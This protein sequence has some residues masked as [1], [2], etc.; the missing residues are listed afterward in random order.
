MRRLT[1]FLLFSILTAGTALASEF[2]LNSRRISV[3]DGLSGNTINELVQD[4]DGYVWMATNNGLSR[5]DGYSTVNYTSLSSDDRRRLEARIGRI[6]YDGGQGLLWMRTATFMN[7]CYDLAE[8]RFVDWTAR[9]DELRQLN[10]FFLSRHR[11]MFFFGYGFGLRRTQRKDGRFLLTDYKAADG[12]LPSDEVLMLLEDEAQNIWAAT[13]RGVARLGTDELMHHHLKGQAI[14]DAATAA[15]R[16][17]FLST[18]GVATVLDGEGREVL[19]S[20]LPA[21]VGKVGKVNI[22]FV[23]Q[24]RWMLFTPTGTLAMD[25]KSGAW[26]RE[27]GAAA[28]AGGLNQGQLP[29]YHFVANQQGRLLVF[30]DEGPCTAMDLIPNARFASMVGRKFHVATDAEGRLFIATYGNGLFVW[31]PATGQRRHFT[32]E[33]P[34]PIIRSNYLTCIM[35]DRQGGIWV[36]SEATGA[37]CLSVMTGTTANYV[38][39]EPT[40]QGDWANAV[41]AVGQRRDGTIIIGTREGGIYEYDRGEGT[42]RKTDTRQANVTSLFVDGDHRL[43]I[44]TNGEGLLAGWQLY[45]KDDATYHLPENKITDILQDREG[46]IWIATRDGGLLMTQPRHAAQQGQPLSFSQYLN[47]EMNES[48]LHDIELDPQGVLWIA[49]NN[50]IYRLDTRQPHISEAS[51]KRY[52]ATN[53][54]FPANEIFTLHYSPAD[55]SLWVGAAGLGAVKCRF[56]EQGDQLLMT[57]VTTRHGLANNNV[58]SLAEDA[59]G[60]I[61]AGTEEGISRINTRNNIVNNYQPSPVLQGNV[62]TENCVLTTPDGTLLFGTNYGLITM[63]PEPDQPT[64]T[65]LRARITDLRQDGRSVSVFFSNFNYSNVQASLYQ[66]YLEG[67]EEDWRPM[68][69]DH[70]ADYQQLAPGHYVFHL[71]SLGSDNEWQQETTLGIDVPHPW[72]ATWWAWLAYLSVAALFGWYVYRN[73]RERFRLHQQMKVGQQVNEFRLQFF[74]SIT[75]EFR[76]PLAIIKGALDKLATDTG[77]QHALQTAQR[78]TKRLLKLVNQLMEFRKVSTGNLSLHP[79]QGDIIGFV[80]ATCQDFWP[81]AQQKSIQTTFI[82]FARS[83]PMTFDRQVV[84]T[85]VYNLVSNAIKYTPDGGSVQV[86]VKHDGGQIAIE[87]EDSGPGISRK[88]Q[89]ALFQPFMKGL[90]SQG[91]MGI[92]LYTAHQMAQAHHGTLT[93]QLIPTLEGKAPTLK[94]SGGS[95]FVFTLPDAPGE[96]EPSAAAAAPAAAAPQQTEEAAPLIHPMP[97]KALN[98]VTIAIVEDD[99]D[100]MEQ[101]RTELGTYFHT[102]TYMNGRRAYEGI[103]QQ[104]PAL[105]VSDVMLPDMDGYAITR[106]LRANALTASIPVILLTA[107]DGEDYQLKAYRAGADDFMVKPCNPRLL[108]GRMMQLLAW[109]GKADG[110]RTESSPASEPAPEPRKDDRLPLI[111]T[112]ADKVF[113]DRLSML[114][115]QHLADESFTVDQLAELMQMGRTKFYGKVRELTGLSPNKLLMQERMKKAA[116]LLADGELTVAEVSYK[117]GIQDPSYFN[118]CFKAHFGVA[119]SKYVKPAE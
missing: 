88:Q 64:A 8:G 35:A 95:L 118:K 81:I 45:S 39:P 33:D 51:F 23:W 85:V 15:G 10:K 4:G 103:C 59:Y 60:Y 17:F 77:D 13:D 54:R 112:Q 22:S 36:G 80:K 27:Q 19:R 89:A 90:A 74:T 18:T 48:R 117:V 37:Y 34:N 55:S 42:M 111:A 76:T 70:Q 25:T 16:T 67:L 84:E 20:Q 69:V 1:L 56:D 9:G 5:F 29:G 105:V 101:L 100:M 12:Q 75:H 11:G 47:A 116:D 79:A 38:L 58:Y 53:G 106:Q 41:S 108:V 65:A 102:Q 49:S 83:H 72:Y 96:N 26:S 63:V 92:G 43:W 30:P 114:V 28:I 73:W 110:T 62:A 113:R 82:P 2:N 104:R 44:G 40:H 94:G 78:G 32:A 87:V 7:V 3:Q 6:V 61:W 24:G 107:L 98:D 97:P 86:R 52:N 109:R 14:V 57:P 119:P 99:P 91:G 31:N 66:Y 46:R 21:S 50:G 93:Y 115:A 68:T 71:R